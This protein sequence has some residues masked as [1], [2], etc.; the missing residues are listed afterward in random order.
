M[1]KKTPEIKGGI[2]KD[3]II[4]PKT[5]LYSREY[6]IKYCKKEFSR[7]IRQSYPLSVAVMEIE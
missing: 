2:K 7:A 3:F 6:F 4:H 1:K 5:G